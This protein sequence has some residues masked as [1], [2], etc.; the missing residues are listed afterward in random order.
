MKLLDDI[1]KVSLDIC[2]EAIA[3]IAAEGTAIMRAGK[4]RS[5]IVREIIIEKPCKRK[6]K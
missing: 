5:D 6:L 4:S 2:R 3:R 1:S